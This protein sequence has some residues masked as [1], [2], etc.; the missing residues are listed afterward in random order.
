MTHDYKRNGTT[1]LFAALNT[2]NGSVMQTCL[3]KHRHQEWIKF[4]NFIKRH[5][6]TD[7][8]IHIICDNYAT[9][10]HPRSSPGSH[11]TLAFT[12]ISRQ[13]AHPG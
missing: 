6:P 5:S 11:A 10:K 12:C 7:K 8:A 3:P 4:L 9:H 1:T 2:L 13:P